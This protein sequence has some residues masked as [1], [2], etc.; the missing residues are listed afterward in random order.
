MR[1]ARRHDVA[2]GRASVLEIFVMHVAATAGDWGWVT[3]FLI[4]PSRPLAHT[5]SRPP[6]L[7]LLS[8]V[9]DAPRGAGMNPQTPQMAQ[10]AQM[11]QMTQ[12]QMQQMA[13]QMAQVR[14]AQQMRRSQNE[15]AESETETHL[16]ALRVASRVPI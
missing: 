6:A 4:S 11:A 10:M 1:A 15:A 9:Q 7:P 3:C 5:L 14:C 8:L 12:Q 16:N 13:Q 2:L